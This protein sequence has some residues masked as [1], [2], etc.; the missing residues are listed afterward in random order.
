V[1]EMK[2]I[3]KEVKVVLKKLQ[4][5]MKKYADRNRKKVVEYKIGDRMLISTKDFIPQMM[6]RLMKKLTEK[7]IRLYKIKRIISENVVELELPVSL[8]VHLVDNVSRIV[9]YQ[10]Q[11]K[12]QKK[13]PSPYYMLSLPN[14]S[15]HHHSDTALPTSNLQAYLP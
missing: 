5:E 6:N 14:W 7:Y 3:H 4:K 1:K 8:K 13:I 12:R 2:E 10:E 9:K 15:I 11:V